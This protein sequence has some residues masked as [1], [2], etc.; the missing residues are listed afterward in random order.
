MSRPGGD[1]PCPQGCHHPVA[2]EETM[3]YHEDEIE[4]REPRV[5]EVNGQTVVQETRIE[6][7]QRCIVCGWRTDL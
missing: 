6:R 3:E 1:A 5:F 7:Y 4:R 2:G